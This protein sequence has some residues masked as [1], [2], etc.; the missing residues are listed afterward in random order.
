MKLYYSPGACSLAPH[1]VLNEIGAQFDL[2]Q[3]DLRE[4]VIQDGDD[5]TLVNP[6]G[7]VPAL[8]LDNQEVLTES[9]A[10]LQYIAD[11]HPEAGLVP[12]SGTL[13]R[14]RLHEIL[15]FL[16]SDLHKAFGPLFMNCS[17]EERESTLALIASKFNY[18]NGV[19]S[20]REYLVENKFSVADIYL[21]VIAGWTMPLGINLG[22]WPN[23]AAFVGRIAERPQVVKSMADE[24]LFS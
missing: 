1:I 16:T 24:G 5:F 19:L 20:D 22:E 17:D 2:V 18:L 7:R 12:E 15:N 4:K 13:A 8:T 3:V 6:H 23:L 14:A 11:Q 21:F 9:V 10:V